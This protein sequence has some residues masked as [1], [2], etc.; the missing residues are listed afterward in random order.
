MCG[1]NGDL[2]GQKIIDKYG[3]LY[4][5][6]LVLPMLP[7][8]FFNLIFLISLVYCF[9]TFSTVYSIEQDYRAEYVHMY[10]LY[11]VSVFRLLDLRATTPELLKSTDLVFFISLMSGF[12][13]Q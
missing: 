8:L 13:Q 7:F 3:E 11:C 12:L 5:P 4:W 9:F 10:V 1:S 2:Y 6:K